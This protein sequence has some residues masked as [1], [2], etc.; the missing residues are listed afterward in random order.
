MNT[1]DHLERTTSAMEGELAVE[2]NVNTLLSHQLDVADSYSQR[3]CMIIKGLRK[4]ENSETK[5][6]E[7]LNIIL[8]DGKEAGID[9]NDFRK[10]VEK[11]HLIGGA[12]TETKQK[13]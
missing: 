4:P 13:L 5:K 2:L 1:V 6:Q 12:K 9:K 10:H 7:R 8:A 11:T 3:S